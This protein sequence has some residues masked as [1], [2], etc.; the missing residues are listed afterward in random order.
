M[1][2]FPWGVFIVLAIGLNVARQLVF[3]PGRVGTAATVGLF[4]V[5]LGIS[6]AV[7]GLLRALGMGRARE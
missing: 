1:P 3:P 7:V 4:F 6:Y 2:R 5:V